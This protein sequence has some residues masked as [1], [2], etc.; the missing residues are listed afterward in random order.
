L[1]LW[2]LL[3]FAGKGNRKVAVVFGFTA[4]SCHRAV[5]Y[6]IQQQPGI[7]I[8]LFSTVQPTAESVTLCERVEFSPS[9]VG[10]II[11]AQ[12]ALWPNRVVLSLGTWTG[13][14]GNWFL[15]LA[16]F[17]IPPFRTLLLNENGDF[18]PGR[19]RDVRLHV[20]RRIR[21]SFH[22]WWGRLRNHAA[23]FSS[24]LRDREISFRDRIGAISLLALAT[25]LQACRSPHRA[26]FYRLHGMSELAVPQVSENSGASVV[27]YKQTGTSWDAT[28][29]RQ[30][31]Q[32]SS[33]RWVE[34]RCDGDHDGAIDDLAML[35]DDPL[36]FAVSRQC[37]F[38]GWKPVLFAT[39]PFRKLQ[40]GE[41]ARLLAPLSGTIL[42]SREK[43]AALGV[44]DAG[45]AITG[46]LLLFWKA[47]A[48]GWRS[49][50][51]GQREPLGAEPEFPVQETAFVLRVLWNRTWRMLGPR[52]PEL[53][54][55]NIAFSTAHQRGWQRQSVRRWHGHRLLSC[56]TS[57]ASVAKPG[58]RA[59]PLRVLVVSPFLPYPL[60]HGGAVRIFNLCRALSDRVDF[61]LV[62]V[63][64]SG[65]T[66]DYE[67]LHEVF[68]DVW[69][70]DLDEPESGDM[71]LPRQVRRYQSQT[72]RSLVADLCH[73]WKPDLLQIEYTHLADLREAANGTPAILVEHD[74]TLDLYRQLAG[75]EQSGP[76]QREYRRW[77]VFE[78]RWLRTY[79]G[80]WTVSEEE[81]RAAIQHGNRR[82]D[83]T[84]DIPNGVDTLR[85][86]PCET[87][88]SQLEILYVGSFRHLPNVLGFE[89]L[90]EEI[91]PEVWAHFPA[92]M[93]RVVAGPNH[94]RFRRMLKGDTGSH[95]AELDE[96]VQV[97]G[98]VE[99]LRPLYAQARIVVAPLAVSSGTNIKVLEAMACGKPIVSTPAGCGGLGLRDGHDVFLREDA[100]DFAGAICRLLSDKDLRRQL[101]GNARRTA[102]ERFG[103]NTIAPR[104]FESYLAVLDRRQTPARETL[105][106]RERQCIP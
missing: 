77:L 67:K 84:F 54:R 3:H 74:L 9:A 46:W 97:L 62:A 80:V 87:A 37:H 102:D 70:V 1:F 59:A 99:D 90:C 17:V 4:S 16:P 83:R 75:H 28:G 104:A 36:T 71:Q 72:L 53:S 64:E 63:R 78:Q 30:L 8:W 35:F 103:W 24:W 105:R 86:Q 61:G 38:R 2:S 93:L 52:Q 58:R 40:P 26:L 39:S 76:A 14:P 96:R 42:V 50:A 49:Y 65:D 68:R 22:C 106:Q 45:L 20:R 12:V 13:E 21:D 56:A 25:V 34:W 101:G 32:S 5:R 95:S 94:E 11:R 33:A 55:G 29:L 6:L 15:K 66:V 91:M 88:I 27:R 73:S 60:T 41:A 31:V 79:E 69:M 23:S 10:L 100:R 19:L 7:P 51:V 44:P 48:A 82:G 92:A 85:F 18:L 89:R 57:H 98:F 47:A 43:L 81:R